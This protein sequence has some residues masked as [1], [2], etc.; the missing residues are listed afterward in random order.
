MKVCVTGNLGFIGKALSK[1][2]VEKGYDVIGFD[3]LEWQDVHSLIEWKNIITSFFNDNKPE[4]VFH[5]GACSDTLNPNYNEMMMLNAESTFII[6]NW[7]KDNEVPIIYSSSASCYGFGDGPLSIYAWSK[8]IGEQYVKSN[9]GVSLRYFNV[10]GYDESHKGKMASLA[11]QSHIKQKNGGIVQL[12]P[13]K[14]QRDFVYIKDVISANIYAL[15]NYDILSGG[16]FDVGTGNARYF[17]DV[18]DIMHIPYRIDDK[19][20]LPPG[21][22]FFTKAHDFRFMR[23]WKPMW[24]LEDGLNDY[25]TYLD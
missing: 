18:M 12:F 11:Y 22:Q 21:Y 8:Y 6:S 4:V 19:I 2:L 15:E 3:K 17:E 5:V 9:G 20:S 13:L 25:K 23:G 7:C 1:E 10:Y 14:P 16:V 24:N